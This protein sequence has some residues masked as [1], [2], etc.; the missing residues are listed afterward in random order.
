[1]KESGCGSRLGIAA[2][3]YTMGIIDIAGRYGYSL[4]KDFIRYVPGELDAG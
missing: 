3:F 4:S 2:G 1:M